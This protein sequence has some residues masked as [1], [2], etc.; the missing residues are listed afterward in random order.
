VSTAEHSRKY[1]GVALLEFALRQRAIAGARHLRILAR[2]QHMVDGSRRCRRHTD[3]QVTEQQH[4]P[5][6]HAGWR[7]G[8]EH[9]HHRGEHDQRDDLELAQAQVALNS[10]N[11][12]YGDVP[13]LLS[14]TA[15]I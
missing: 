10:V 15:S 1:Q 12:R 6:H 2:I 5:R 7:C 8:E 14:R 3:T 9:A 13:A 11:H 4:V